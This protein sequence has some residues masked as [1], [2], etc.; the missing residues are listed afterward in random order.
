VQGQSLQKVSTVALKILQDARKA[1]GYGLFCFIGILSIPT[2]LYG[3]GEE[4]DRQYIDGNPLHYTVPIEEAFK[5]GK[6]LELTQ[7]LLPHLDIYS[8]MWRERNK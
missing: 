8:L 4:R 2:F 7:F 6:N 3:G 1:R 5:Y